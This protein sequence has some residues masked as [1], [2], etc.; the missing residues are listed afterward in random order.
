MSS[1]KN[2]GCNHM[3]DSLLLKHLV[4]KRVFRHRLINLYNMKNVGA[5]VAEIFEEHVF[6]KY[7][8]LLLLVFS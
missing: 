5:I 7:F 3:T 4:V 8:F 1:K 6:D 2:T